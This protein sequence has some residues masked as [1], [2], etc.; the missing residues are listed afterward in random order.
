[1]AIEDVHDLREVGQGSGKSIDL[2]DY[3][4]VHLTRGDIREQ[5]LQG[6]SIEIAT[7]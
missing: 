7:G 2:I 6:W 4:D 5:L 3:D 1:V